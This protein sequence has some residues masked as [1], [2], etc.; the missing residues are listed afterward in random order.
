[1]SMKTSADLLELPLPQVV[2]KARETSDETPDEVM[3]SAFSE[4]ELEE[5]M[6]STQLNKSPGPDGIT[7]EMILHLGVKSRGVF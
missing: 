7:N 1:M 2:R 3:T 6:Q 4:K 5:A